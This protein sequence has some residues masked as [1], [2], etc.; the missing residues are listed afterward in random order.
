MKHFLIA[1]LVFLC[2]FVTLQAQ[3][4]DEQARERFQK[5]EEF[6]EKGNNYECLPCVPT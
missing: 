1:T 4:S 5:A 2:C 3:I 6:Y